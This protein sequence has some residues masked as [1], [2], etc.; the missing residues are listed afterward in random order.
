L[1][2]NTQRVWGDAQIIPL[3]SGHSVEVSLDS[4]ESIAVRSPGGDVQVQITLTSDGPVVNL[5]GA[6]LNL[7]ATRE[8]SVRCETFEVHSTEGTTLSSEGRLDM[9]SEDEMKLVSKSDLRA[10]AEMIH[11]N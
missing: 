7:E 10:V 1:S 11:L 3:P 8:V 6:R 5:T 9:S 2:T 4:G